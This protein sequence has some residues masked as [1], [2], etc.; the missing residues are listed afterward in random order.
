[1]DSA[2]GAGAQIANSRSRCSAGRLDDGVLSLPQAHKQSAT[3]AQA[4]ATAAAQAASLLISTSVAGTHLPRRSALVAH[5]A[6]VATAAA[7]AAERELSQ[8]S[9]VRVHSE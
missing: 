4:Q 8:S 3:A 2:A 1:M 6:A 7:T 5:S 9:D